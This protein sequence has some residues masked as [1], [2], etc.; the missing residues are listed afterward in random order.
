MKT[1]RFKNL[2]ATKQ[3]LVRAD[4]TQEYEANP[5][6]FAKDITAR[7]I[8]IGN[9][10]K[11]VSEEERS[12]W[13]KR[14]TSNTSLPD[15]VEEEARQIAEKV[16]PNYSQLHS[17]LLAR[18]FLSSDDPNNILFSFEAAPTIRVEG[19]Q[20]EKRYYLA[21]DGSLMFKHSITR[22][23]IT[24]TKEHN[25]G[26]GIVIQP[27]DRISLP[28]TL[29]VT[30]K[31]DDPLNSLEVKIENDVLLRNGKGL[32]E[33]N[34]THETPKVLGKVAELFAQ[35]HFP[36]ELNE[37]TKKEYV[38]MI[39]HYIKQVKTAGYSEEDETE[40]LE[41]AC[42]AKAN[43]TGMAVNTGTIRGTIMPTLPEDS[44]LSERIQSFQ[45]EIV[46]HEKVLL[47]NLPKRIA[48][49]F[50]IFCRKIKAIIRPKEEPRV[51][52]LTVG[53]FGGSQSKALVTRI[54]RD[55]VEKD[56]TLK[57]ISDPSCGG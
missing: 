3:A 14:L 32:V 37:Q 6:L 57:L 8:K 52:S 2:S 24:A 43:L 10:Q 35:E 36:N 55:A 41:I 44:P 39:D 50:E 38:T 23:A 4:F 25:M 28:T 5:K 54:K 11:P 19:S 56:T 45:N 13:V 48:Y 7:D 42:Q 30:M 40:K 9:S 47:D 22:L 21:Q 16:A 46:S 15:P 26:H 49:A 12:A 51:S 33:T 27:S 20:S 18:L 34:M 1:L 53:L 31:V 17:Y 29:T